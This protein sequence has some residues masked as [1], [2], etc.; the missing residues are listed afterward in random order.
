MG[1]NQLNN[2]SAP[3]CLE[4]TLEKCMWMKK[5]AR[6]KEIPVCGESGLKKTLMRESKERWLAWLHGKRNDKTSDLIINGHAAE[7]SV[8]HS[9]MKHEYKEA[10]RSQQYITKN[11]Q[12]EVKGEEGE[13]SRL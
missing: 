12:F 7:S 10:P 9:F 8:L 13:R 2:A 3:L 11:L 5:K 1:G 4:E 6:K